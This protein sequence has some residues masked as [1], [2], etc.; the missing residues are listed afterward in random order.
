MNGKKRAYIGIDIGGTNLRL[1]LIDE[2][3]AIIHKTKSRTDIHHG[4]SSFFSRLGKGIES[5]LLAARD[6]NIEPAGLGAG[7]P[8]LIANDGHV[9]VSVN[10]RPLD[11]VNLRDELQAMSGLPA[12]V[13]NDVN[14]FAFGESVYGAGRDYRSFLMVTLGTGVGG[15]L[16]LGGKVWTG[17]DGVAGEFGHMTVEAEGRPCP[18]GN[19]GCLEQ[20]AS[21]SAL[22]SAAREMI[23]Q[24]KDVFGAQ[25]DVAA[26]STKILAAAALD[27]NQ[28]AL[29]LFADAGRYLGIAAASVANL[30]NLEAIILGGGVSSSFNL[31][32]ESMRREVL[33]R[34]FPIPGKRLVIRQASLGDDGGILGSAALARSFLQ[35]EKP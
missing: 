31:L 15:G 6:N 9:Y 33:A 13:A 24:Q 8:G 20:Y 23:C 16:I 17:I 4:R 27:G 5:L 21:A 2:R 30:L 3:G 29:D 26:I 12:V 35:E 7:V 18:C 10:L 22:V 11:G 34:A 14:A 25:C 19:R 32:C 1:A 28:A